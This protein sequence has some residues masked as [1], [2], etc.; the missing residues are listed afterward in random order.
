MKLT[1]EE[2]KILEKLKYKKLKADKKAWAKRKLYM[3]K[4]MLTYRKNNKK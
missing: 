2:E 1:K 4:Y 3:K